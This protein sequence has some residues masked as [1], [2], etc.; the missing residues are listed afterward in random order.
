MKRYLL[1]HAIAL[2]Q[3]ANVWLRGEPDETL[4]SRVHRMRL[5]GHRWW[6]WTAGAIDRLFFWQDGHCEAAYVSEVERRQAQ[7]VRRLIIDAGAW[8]RSPAKES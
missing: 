2:D 4:S 5:K 8:S 1:A 3:W 7:A 6:G